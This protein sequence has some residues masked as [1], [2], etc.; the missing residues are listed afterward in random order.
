MNATSLRASARYVM[1]PV[2][3]DAARGLKRRLSREPATWEYMPGGWR[4]A[5]A[6]PRIKGW[7][8]ASVVEAYQSRWPGFLA[9]LKGTLPL[10][11]APER[12]GMPTGLAT[13]PYDE[14]DVF[15][16]NVI[17]T[18]GYVL[19][20]AARGKSEISMLDW[21]GGIGHYYPISQTLVPDLRIDYHCKDV[22][23]PVEHGKTLFPEAH[24]YSDEACLGRTYDLV[25]ASGAYHYVEDWKALLRG[26]A[27]ATAGHLFI[28]QLPIVHRAPSF[29][30]VQRPYH[31]GYDTEYL[32]WCFNRDEFLREAEGAGLR[33]T[34]EV[35]NGYKP[36]IHNAPEQAEYRGYLFTPAGA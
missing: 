19:G 11:I 12:G 14:Y 32:G 25:L 16:H 27:G 18:F 10:C 4:V 7:N 17:M 31:H 35:V 5:E 6:D 30:M 24:F 1:P 34:R 13:T 21:G 28:T 33:L 15:Y 3:F 26:L 8:A 2:L 20:R 22:P 36:P 29:V 23:A 9:Y